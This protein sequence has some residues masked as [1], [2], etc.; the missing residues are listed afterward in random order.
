MVNKMKLPEWL[1]QELLSDSRL[2]IPEISDRD[3]ACTVLPDL[4]YEAQLIAISDVLRHHGEVDTRT[5]AQIKELEDFARKST[6]LRNEQAVDEWVDLLNRATY[7]EAA[8]SMAALGMLAPLI[9]SLFYQAFQGIRAHYYGVDV[10]PK[11]SARSGMVKADD[12]W[13][14]HLLF[15]P[16]KSK[17]QKELVSGIM[18]LAEAIGLTPH[19]PG[20]LLPILKALF[21]YRNKMF[22]FGFE[23]PAKE[24]AKFAK[25]ISDEGWD[26]WFSSATRDRVPFIFYMTDQLVDRSFELMHQLLEGLGAYCRTK[27]RIEEE[28]P[29]EV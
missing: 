13:D 22:H 10:I 20:D 3:M 26:A 28:I 2:G 12:F 1:Q 8:H 18:Q 24:C 15:N 25:R 4:D 23:W 19:L 14:C 27:V 11:D 5:T 6:G 17:K 9:E 7:Q 16:T 29:T 21:E